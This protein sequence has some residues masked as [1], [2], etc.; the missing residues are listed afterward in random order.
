MAEMMN[1]YRR[2]DGNGWDAKRSDGKRA[3]VTAPTQQQAYDAAKRILGN[4]GGGEVA[5][6]GR[7]GQIRDKHT[8]A[9]GNDPRSIRG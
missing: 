5:I 7:N 6:H 2:T 9:P 1:V 8:I 4:N 3:S